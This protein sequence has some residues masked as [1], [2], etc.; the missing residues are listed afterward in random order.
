MGCRFSSA[1][2]ATC[3]I[4][5]VAG[6]MTLIGSNRLSAAQTETSFS[7]DVLPILKDNCAGCHQPGGEGYKKS[8]VDL[9]SYKGVMKGTKYGTM[10]VP[11]NP[12]ASNLVMLIEWRTGGE[13]HMPHGKG[14]LPIKLRETIRRWVQ[15]GARNN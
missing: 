11:G 2:T 4:A 13:I 6:S 5:F 10:V 12:E 3:G 14:Q 15:E 1:L 8:G 9:T 7:R